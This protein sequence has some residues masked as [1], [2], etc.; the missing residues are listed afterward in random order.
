[1]MVKD[2]FAEKTVSDFWISAIVFVCLSAASLGVMY[3]TPILPQHHRD[4]E[5]NTVVRLV[6][7]I[8][9]VMTSLVFGLM[10]NASRSTYEGVD[11]NVHAYAT[12]MILLDRSLRSYGLGGKDARVRLRDYVTVAIADPSRADET[13]EA[14]PDR[15]GK[16]LD[17]LSDALSVIEPDNSYHEQLLLDIKQQ[18][19]SLVQQRWVLLEQSEGGVPFPLLG[20]LVAWLVVIFASFGYRAPHNKVVVS[21]FIVA[22]FLISS[23]FYLVLDMNIPFDGPIQISDQPLR[24]VL[25]QMDH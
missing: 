15:A 22:S 9:V 23:A 10:L 4:E 12:N 21:S 16:A 13:F 11:K 17:A 19:R 25:A 20:V 8:F 14:M 2:P 18:Y 1:M 24:R 5:T 6:A 3:L 7:N